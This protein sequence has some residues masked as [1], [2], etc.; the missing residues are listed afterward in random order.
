MYTVL[1]KKKSAKQAMQV[2]TSTMDMPMKKE[3]ALNAP[4]GM[5]LNS[6]KLP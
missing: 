3:A 1:Q 5:L 4:E 6:V 2:R